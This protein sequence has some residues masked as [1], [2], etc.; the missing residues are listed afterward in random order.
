MFFRI[1]TIYISIFF[2]VSLNGQTAKAD[3]YFQTGNYKEAIKLYEKKLKKDSA[4]AILKKLGECYLKNRNYEKAESIYFKVF[5]NDSLNLENIHRY[6]SVLQN[7][8]KYGP[9]I[10]QFEKLRSDMKYANRSAEQIKFCKKVQ[11]S[12]TKDTTFKVSNI[13]LLNTKENEF[14]PFI[15]NDELYY[16]SEGKSSAMYEAS[17]DQIIYSLVKRK[18][19]SSKS[20]NY[21]FANKRSIVSVINKAGSIGAASYSDSSKI[22]YFTFVP[23]NTF[24]KDTGKLNRPAIY[25]SKLVRNKWTSPEPFFWNNPSYSFQ[26]PAISKDGKVLIFASNMPGGYGKLDLYMCVKENEQWSKPKN[27][28]SDVNT[29]ENEVFPY[30]YNSSMLYFSSDGQVGFGALDIF[31]SKLIL[32]RWT[33]VKNV[34]QLVNSNKD[35]FGICFL[36]KDSIGIV[37]SNRSGGLG[38][39]DLYRISSLKRE[40]NISFNVYLTENINDPAIGRKVYLLNA[41]GEKID[42]AYTDQFGHFKFKTFEVDKSYMIEVV[43]DDLQFT[44]KAR[45]YILDTNGTAQNITHVLNSKQRY[46]FRN[47]PVDVTSMPD[48]FDDI[49]INLAGNVL[50]GKSADKPLANRNIIIKNSFGDIVQQTKTNA[51]GSFAFRHLPTNQNYLL[52]ID[53][54]NISADTKITVTNKKGKEIKVNRLYNKP[55]FKYQLLEVEKSSLLDLQVDDNE[56]AMDLSGFILDQDK[57]EIANANILILENDS[58]IR[59]IQT[60]LYGK[61]QVDDLSAEKTY[62]FSLND[63]DEKFKNVTKIYL[64]NTL[65]RIYREIERRK[66][67]KF[68]FKLLE[69]DKQLL[70]E[71]SLEDPW[72]QVLSLTTK[73]EKAQL[74]IS[75]SFNYPSGEWKVDNVIS[76]ILDKVVFI[77]KANPSLGIVL[78]SHTDSQG[79]DDFNMRLSEKRAQ[80]AYDYLVSKK[81]SKSRLNAIGYGESKILNE[82]V[83]N[84]PCD[85]LDHSVN[86]RTEFKIFQV[87]SK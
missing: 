19:I 7:Q 13:G 85:D 87:Q 36:Y 15:L 26:H 69:S 43:E 80:A 34:G 38:G 84:I 81:I 71:V 46:V 78:M 5:K 28:G 82:C 24:S 73:E 12:K 83:N 42:S 22:L 62:V 75:E 72:L 35:D 56:L 74:T 45:Y 79:A 32:D 70:G 29:P 33:F 68:E 16:T 63:P 40:M 39:D 27:L 17:N 49:G 4:I 67:G 37:S 86:R 54:E 60:D 11:L 14:S 53:D 41:A 52:Y 20:T 23:A 76:K 57:K 31:S 18:I 6:A 77:L 55:N 44:N 47:L 51:L 59:N 48:V 2:T 1:I 30:L 65:K 64:T 58:V 9:A 8:A 50:L 21:I 3:R 66:D 61:F 10:F 25:S